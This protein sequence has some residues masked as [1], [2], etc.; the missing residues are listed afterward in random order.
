MKTKC[1]KKAMEHLKYS[2]GWNQTLRY[3]SNVSI[4]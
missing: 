4:K 3:K 2:Y 1:K